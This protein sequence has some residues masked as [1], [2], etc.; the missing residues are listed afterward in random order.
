MAA[1]PSVDV[2]RTRGPGSSRDHMTDT[3]PDRCLQPYRPQSLRDYALIADGERGALV[4]PHGEYMWMYAPRWD[5]G[6]VF[7]GLI[8][9]PGGYAP[10]PTGRYVWGGHHEEDSL[11][12]RSRWVTQEGVVEC[13]EALAFPGD[14]HR[15]AVLRRVL[16]TARLDQDGPKLTPAYTVEG[17]PIPDQRRLDLPGYP[18]GCDLVGNQ[19]RHQF[20]LDAFGECL[21][22]LAA[23]AGHDRLDKDGWKAVLTAADAI[24]QRWREPD[25][26]VWEL[27]PRRWTHSRLIRAA[28]LRA[29]ARAGV[30]ASRTPRWNA[31]ADAITADTHRHSLHSSGRWQRADDDDR[32]DAALLLPAVRGALPGD[33]PRTVETLRAYLAE[34]TDDHFASRFRHDD[35]RPARAEDAFVMCG[36][37]VALAEHQQGRT[38]S[39]YRWFEH[40]RTALRPRGTLSRGVPHRA[41][42]Y[43]RHPSPGVRPRPEDGERRSAGSSLAGPLSGV[44]PRTTI[45]RGGTEHVPDGRHHRSKRRNR[46]GGGPRVRRQG[47]PRRTRRPRPYR[48]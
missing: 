24:E 47:R 29:A 8:G 46:T 18:G 20:Q 35:R 26:G 7:A 3:S 41:A 25:A 15:A 37:A 14:P 21:L 27:S 13:R 39:A 45:R 4:G 9:G 42:R 34:L 40:N 10:T 17:G 48:P 5:S 43:A 11:I 2:E 1:H 36:F 28:G 32:L 31:L 30:P 38:A 33:D 19:V 6:A 23:S 22:L 12:R 44:R 16:I